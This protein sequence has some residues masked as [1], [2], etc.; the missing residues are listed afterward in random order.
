[1]TFAKFKVC[2]FGDGGVGKTTLVNRYLTGLF[3]SD[4]K[5]T[6][7]ADFY[8]KKLEI[9]GKDVTLQI[10]DFCGEQKFRFLLPSYVSGSSGG[11]FMYDITRYSSI[12]S[13]DNWLNVFR[14]SFER[15]EIDIPLLCVGG[16]L[17]LESKR[18]VSSDVVSEIVK[19]YNFFD[20]I[21]CSAKTGKNVEE[22]FRSLSQK[23]IE[24]VNFI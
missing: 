12:V 19:K 10:W 21:E 14:K 6:I 9:D 11:I 15:N 4:F 18:S 23:M 20:F 17:D 8:L 2:V 7:G 24:K 22:I 1:M 5:I 3:S 16:K 13:A